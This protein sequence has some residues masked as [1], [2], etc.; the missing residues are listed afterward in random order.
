[1]L[2]KYWQRVWRVLHL[3]NILM[4]KSSLPSFFS[5]TQQRFSVCQNDTW[6]R[7]SLKNHFIP[8]AATGAP[9]TQGRAAVAGRG[10]LGRLQSYELALALS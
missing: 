3:A 1:V 9:A 6:Q 7:I 5:V 8:S 4:A 2:K 10:A